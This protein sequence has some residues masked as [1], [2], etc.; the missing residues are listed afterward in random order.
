MDVFGFAAM[1][2]IGYIFLKDARFDEPAALRDNAKAFE[3]E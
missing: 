1:A 3:M 2:I